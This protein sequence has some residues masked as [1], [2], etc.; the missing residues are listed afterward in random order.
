MADQ[1]LRTAS[2]ES[3]KCVIATVGGD[4]VTAGLPDKDAKSIKVLDIPKWLNLL[5]AVELIL[6]SVNNCRF[7]QY[8]TYSQPSF[9]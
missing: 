5:K 2:F 7:E 8:R 1:H 9:K 6:T 4:Q 3:W